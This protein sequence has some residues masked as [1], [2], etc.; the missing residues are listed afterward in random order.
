VAPAALVSKRHLITT[1]PALGLEHR[2]RFSASKNDLMNIAASCG[3]MEFPYP[4][5]R[6]TRL[7]IPVATGSVPGSI[8][9]ILVL[10]S[11][12]RQ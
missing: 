11:I 3:T 1:D 12:S 10:P 2:H 8:R 5:I 4:R 9:R 6:P 7:G